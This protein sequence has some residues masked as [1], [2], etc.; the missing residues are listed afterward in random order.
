MNGLISP[1]SMV[2]AG[3]NGVMMRIFS[4]PTLNHLAPTEHHLNAAANLR[5]DDN[6]HSFR[7]AVGHPLMAASRRIMHN[8][9]KLRS[10]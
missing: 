4:W 7:T 6:V 2:Q 10:S 8:V 9:T 1:V 5:I 3:A